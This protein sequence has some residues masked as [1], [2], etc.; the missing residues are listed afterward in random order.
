MPLKYI[1]IIVDGMDQAKSNLPHTKLIAK[2][3]SGLWRVQTHVYG[4]LLHTKSPHGKLAYAFVDL[5]QFPHD[6]NYTITAILSVILDYI[7]G[8]PVPE[9]LY[10]QVDNTAREN[11]NKFLLGFCAILVQL[12]IFKKVSIIIIII[13]LFVGGITVQLCI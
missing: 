12:K 2:S 6:S 9:T 7:R 3:T 5:L 1:T 4:A 10:I 8:H 13:I 11:K